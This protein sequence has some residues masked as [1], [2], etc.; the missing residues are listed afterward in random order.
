MRWRIPLVL[1]LAA[2]ASVSCDQSMTQPETEA[3]QS[4][5]FDR[6]PP[7]FQEWIDLTGDT[8]DLCGQELVDLTGG[9]HHS[10][11]FVYDEDSGRG[12]WFHVDHYNLRFVGQST[13]YIWKYNDTTM[14]QSQWYETADHYGPDAWMQWNEHIRVIGFRDAPSFDANNMVHLTVNANGDLATYHEKFEPI[15][16]G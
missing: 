6:Q 14:R 7:A 13:G 16:D 5:Q 3:A 11:R 12:H 9:L 4:S 1:A 2:L 15:C 8:W 10:F